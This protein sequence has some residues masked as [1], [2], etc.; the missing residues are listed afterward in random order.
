MNV[1]LFIWR[2]SEIFFSGESVRFMASKSVVIEPF[3]FTFNLAVSYSYHFVCVGF[4][5]FSV[6]PE[7]SASF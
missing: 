2:R 1:I 3:S 7:K 5:P 4:P 6:F